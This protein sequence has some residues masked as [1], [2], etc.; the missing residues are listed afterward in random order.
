MGRK[1]GSGRG[2]SIPET[3]CQRLSVTRLNQVLRKAYRTTHILQLLND[4]LAH[5]LAL[6]PVILP[7][8]RNLVQDGLEPVPGKVGPSEEWLQ[9]RSHD[10][11]YKCLFIIE[12][13]T[14]RS[15]S[16]NLRLLM[17]PCGQSSSEDRISDGWRHIPA[18][19]SCT[20][21]RRPVAPLDLL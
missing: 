11:G 17:S 21:Y 5:C 18:G 1:L 15:T 3:A 19:K 7:H 14:Y 9:A 2:R 4:V 12:K 6:I 13:G 10:W 8:I 20:S 16:A